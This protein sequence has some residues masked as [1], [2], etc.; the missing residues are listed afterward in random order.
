MI[1]NCQVEFP[2]QNCDFPKIFYEIPNKQTH[3]IKNLPFS[4]TPSTSAR[5]QVVDV[6]L[7]PTEEAHKRGG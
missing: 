2:I 7:L 5:Y 6:T 3:H 4:D 1:E